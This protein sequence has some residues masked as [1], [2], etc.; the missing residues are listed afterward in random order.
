[1]NENKLF[2]ELNLIEIDSTIINNKTTYNKRYACFCHWFDTLGLWAFI[3][4]FIINQKTIYIIFAY[5]FYIHYLI[6]ELCS[7][8]L[9]DL[10]SV[11]N[12]TINE[13]IEKFIKGKPNLYLKCECFHYEKRQNGRSSY[14]IDEV[15]TYSETI[16]YS[17]ISYRDI[18]G[19]LIL[20]IDVSDIKKKYY[21]KLEIIKKVYLSDNNSI[22]H[23]YA[24]KKNIIEKNKHRDTYIRTYNYIDIEGLP[25]FYIIKLKDDDP[26]LIGNG[27]WYL[28]FTLLTL[29]EFYKIY[30]N[31]LFLYQSF[32][33]K[34]LISISY[35]VNMDQRFNSFSPY[36][37]Y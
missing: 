19:L 3:I 6:L 24:L 30:V 7:P 1:M 32:T 9:K 23:Y 5:I 18:S 11:S 20:N 10:C 15:I 4:M 17:Y 33:I 13:I 25:Y 37:A 22:S 8:M 2:S 34:K 16:N 12:Q 36:K 28:I 21:I 29:V 26:W 14:T 27:F 31:S 35:D